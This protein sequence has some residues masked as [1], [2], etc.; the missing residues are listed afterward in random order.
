MLRG[1]RLSADER[2]RALEAVVAARAASQ[3]AP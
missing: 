1:E 2:R 3:A